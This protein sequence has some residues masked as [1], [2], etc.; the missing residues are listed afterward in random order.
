MELHRPP[1]LMPR[2]GLP[3]LAQ[4]MGTRKRQP[5]ERS[6]EKR[7][8]AVLFQGRSAVIGRED[9]SCFIETDWSKWPQ[10]YQHYQYRIGWHQ[11][12]TLV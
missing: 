8:E 4:E 3:I 12:I 11:L 6:L 10:D 9:E 7:K 1:L 5:P 2:K